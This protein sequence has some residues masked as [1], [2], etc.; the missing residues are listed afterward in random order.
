MTSKGPG[1]FLSILPGAQT[2]L[3][4]TWTFPAV[5][6]SA[7]PQ[8][9]WSLGRGPP[10]S[11]SGKSQRPGAHKQTKPSGPGSDLICAGQQN[12]AGL[13]ISLVH[14]EETPSSTLA[15]QFWSQWLDKPS[16]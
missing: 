3:C 1:H 7:W 11:P 4:C 8:P 16:D 5:L 2:N 15:L 6:H 13:V 12:P 14:E 9:D 10:H